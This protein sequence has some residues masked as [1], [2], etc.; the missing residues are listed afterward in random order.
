MI[1]YFSIGGFALIVIGFI[2]ALIS[3]MLV[4]PFASIGIMVIDSFKKRESDYGFGGGDSYTYEETVSHDIRTIDG[5]VIGTYETTET[6]EGYH[7]SGGDYLAILK[8]LLNSIV[9]LPCRVISLIVAIVSCFTDKFFVMVRR[10][11][12]EYKYNKF[13]HNYFDIVIKKR[14]RRSKTAK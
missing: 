14:K 11:K 12:I 13:L 1:I 5:T 3:A 6:R 7:M 8:F 10:P 4:T 2:P 9:A